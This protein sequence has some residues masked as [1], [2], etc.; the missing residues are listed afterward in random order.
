MNNMFIQKMCVYNTFIQN[1]YVSVGICLDTGY[2][3]RCV[4]IYLCMCLCM[5]GYI[6]LHNVFIGVYLYLY[7]RA[8]IYVRARYS[9]EAARTCSY[10]KVD[11]KP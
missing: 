4:Y 10:V 6:Y 11:P 1:I 7:T 2:I 5:H 8:C 9:A 3:C